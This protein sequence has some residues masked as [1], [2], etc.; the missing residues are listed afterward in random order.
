MSSND[1]QSDELT[2]DREFADT[3][4]GCRRE[5]RVLRR[6]KVRL[7][8]ARAV[9]DAAILYLDADDRDSPAVC[10]GKRR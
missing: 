7:K 2:G 5:L 3:I 10:G 6:E 4:D 8:I 9:H 1:R